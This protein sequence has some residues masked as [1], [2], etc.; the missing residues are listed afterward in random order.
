MD[1]APGPLTALLLRMREG[2]REAEGELFEALYNELRRTARQMLSRER[3]DHTLTPT[4]LVHVAYLR[5]REIDPQAF[6][7]HIHFLRM[8]A[9][10]MRQLLVDQAR[11]YKAEKRSGGRQRV[12]FE[13]NLVSSQQDAD[14]I[15]AVHESLERLREQHPV[16]AEVVEL[17]YF[18]GYTFEEIGPILGM[19]PR[20]A[21]RHWTIARTL[22]RGQIDG[23]IS[24]AAG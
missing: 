19:S 11:A 16:R 7:D 24:V 15:L 9:R 8:A 2:D 20:H 5:L 23:G 10:V 18:S 17:H 22:L 4:A 6:S 3:K 12:E 14:T 21:K 13:D 1:A